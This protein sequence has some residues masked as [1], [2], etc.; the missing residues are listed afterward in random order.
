MLSS[1]SGADTQRRRLQSDCD[2][3]YVFV[4]EEFEFCIQELVLIFEERHGDQ[5]VLFIIEIEERD[6]NQAVFLFLFKLAAEKERN[7]HPQFF[8]QQQAEERNHY[9]QFFFKHCETPEERY[10]HP[11]F[12]F[13][14][15]QTS[16][17][18][19]HYP[20]VQ[21][22]GFGTQRGRS[23]SRGQQQ[24]PEAFGFL[25]QRI[26]QPGRKGQD[27]DFEHR[28]SQDSSR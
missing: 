13:R 9:P 1:C 8:F 18:R 11:Q 10:N 20:P 12:F 2:T 28:L 17:E 22:Q 21:S 25:P 6:R 19:Y 14:H 27:R 15:H 16:E 23:G 5:I 3:Q 7:H 24:R 4:F 26:A